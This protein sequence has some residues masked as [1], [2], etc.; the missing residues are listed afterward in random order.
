MG[1][2]CVGKSTLFGQLADRIS[3]QI[4]TG[5]DDL[6]PEKANRRQG[7]RPNGGTYETTGLYFMG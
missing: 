3:A 5:T 7:S 6:R 4:F 1:E 2:R